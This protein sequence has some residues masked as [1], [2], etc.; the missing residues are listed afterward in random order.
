M[1]ELW[2][3]LATEEHVLLG[4]VLPLVALALAGAAAGRWLLRL[5]RV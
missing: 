1:V 5:R 3:P 2:C 4:H